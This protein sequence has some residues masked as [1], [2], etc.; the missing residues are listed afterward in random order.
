MRIYEEIIKIRGLHDEQEMIEAYNAVGGGPGKEGFISRI[1]IETIIKNDFEMT[2]DI[3]KLLDEVDDNG[4]GE[5][6]YG[7]F[8]K[9]LEVKRK[10]ANKN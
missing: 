4:D 8:K 5:I 2:I 6:Q 1:V 9:I 10:L 7:E 3:K